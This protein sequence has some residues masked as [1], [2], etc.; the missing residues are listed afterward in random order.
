MAKPFIS[1]DIGTH[2][3]KLVYGKRQGVNFVIHKADH[4]KMPRDTYSDG[5][6]I[7]SQK[8]VHGI[9]EIILKNN[10]K[11]KNV[12]LT[13]NSS[14]VIIRELVIPAIKSKELDTIVRYEIMQVLPIE[15]D[16]Y[17]FEYI[18]IGEVVE[19]KVKKNRILVC[20][21]PK[22]TAESFYGLLKEMNLHP[23]GMMITPLSMFNIIDNAAVSINNTKL[24]DESFAILDVG[25]NSLD[26][27]IF[28]DAKLTFSRRLTEG[29]NSIDNVISNSKI[30]SFEEALQIRETLSV[31][32]DQEVRGEISKWVSDIQRAITFNDGRTS[33]P[34]KKVF[35]CGGGSQ[36]LDIARVVEDTLGVDTEI[37]RSISNIKFD[38]QA[39]SAL[40][41]YISAI[42]SLP[43]KK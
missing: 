43:S 41:L 6:I 26:I 42:G 27:N 3:I 34:V 9:Q 22:T 4:L 35:L 10:I 40:P 20:A 8:L 5:K 18:I 19:D 17:I 36:M 7:N 25:H 13:F 29:M 11:T 38:K 39:D 14:N 30:I 24:T 31:D 28:T 2:S 23:H 37:I 32:K 33:K 21:V 15:L 1:L 12:Y 16:Q